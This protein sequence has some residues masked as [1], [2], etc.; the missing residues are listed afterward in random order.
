[1]SATQLSFDVARLPVVMW[2]QTRAQ[3]LNSLR[4]PAFSL[5]TVVLPIMFFAFFGLPYVHQTIANTNITVGPYVMASFGAYAVSSA[6]V[7]NF[8]IGVAMA[9]GQKMDLLQRATPLPPGVAIAATVVNAMLF[10]LVSLIALFIFASIAGGV[11]MPIETWLTLTFRLLVGAVPLIGLGMAIG[12]A[13]G[14]NSA[15]AVT[16]LIYLPMSFASGLFIPLSQLPAVV[17]KV[18]PYLPTYHYGQIA[19]NAVGAPTESMESAVIWLAVWTVLLFGLALRFIR[20]DQN[21]K[22]S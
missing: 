3:V 2:K 12:Y 18:A 22:F 6:M 16:N 5:T 7:F 10:A 11:R 9:R 1:V 15:P 13:A 8:G 4:I 19:W 17:Q 20:L 14:P 21:R